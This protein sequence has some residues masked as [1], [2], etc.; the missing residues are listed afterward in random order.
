[1][2]NWKETE[3]ESF[4]WNDAKKLESESWRLPTIFELEQAFNNK[5]EGFEDYYYWT[6]D[7]F[8]QDLEYAWVFGLFSGYADV[9]NKTDI[10][11][12]R[13]CENK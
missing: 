10:F 9:N 6:A 13:L 4:S 5:T 12:V 7:E 2:L 1:M 8:E 3:K 11:K